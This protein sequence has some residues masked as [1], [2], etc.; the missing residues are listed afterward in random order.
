MQPSS[1]I[2]RYGFAVLAV[3]GAIVIRALLDPFLGD[4]QPFAFFFVA[5]AAAA[6]VG[7]VG[8]ALLAIV[9][10]YIAGDW[11]FVSPRHELSVLTLAPQYVVGGLA[12]VVVGLMIT[13][14]TSGMRAA[15]RFARERELDLAR[16]VAERATAEAAERDSQARLTGIIASATDA[17]ITIDAAHRITMFNA[18][19]ESM[20]GC[21][22]QTVIGETLDRFI[23]ERFR[24]GHADHIRGFGATGINMR[25]MGGERVLAGVRAGGQEF[26]MEA[27]ISQIAIGGEKLYTVIIRDITQRKRAEAE[28]DE[29]L[30]RER[31][32]RGEAEA[33]N[34]AKDSFL[35]T[36]SHEL[37]TPLSPILAWSRMLRQGHVDA[38]KMRGALDVIERCA[39]TQAQ[40]IEDM[41]DVSRI[42]SGK[43][44][45]QV[46]P[47]PLQRV[48]EN[49]VEVVRPAAEA[50]NVRLRVVL[51]TDVGPVLGDAERLQQVVW[52]LLSN[53][54]KFTP[55]DGRIQVAL[56]RVNSHVEVAVSDTGVGIRSETLPF[57]FEPFRQGETGTTR[58]HGGLGLGLAIVKHIVEA[59]GGTVHA[60]SPGEGKGAVFSVKLPL[61]VARTADEPERRHPTAAGEGDVGVEDGYPSLQGLRVLV[62]DDEPHSNEVVSTLL[63]SCG[64]EIRVAVSAPQAR[65]VL[66]RWT[67]DILVSDIEMPGEDGYEL[68]AKL[69]AQEGVGA[70]LPAVALTAYAS[71]EDN[72][73]LLS[74]GFHA[75]VAK[76][77][78]PLEL[79]TV[80][81]NL[82]R[83]AGRASA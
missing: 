82:A 58:T 9:L 83:T 30:V 16:E 24:A 18:A 70:Q 41:L 56:E 28:R 59:H 34:R 25:Q 50:K 72:I 45:M 5:I 54:I 74:A 46:R 12:F 27:R 69:R 61:A 51:D 31:A 38:E 55:K 75:H 68:I 81:A 35:A 14:I 10:G 48:I 73:R 42:I 13:G 32:A 19:A 29:L 37:R 44:R 77:L 79:V 36:I 20:F 67:P 40:L 47:V 65:E 21:S 22:A 66:G 62:V 4:Y 17:I 11:L 49:A 52:N 80:I 8:P 53:A 78:D 33:A 2:P 57:V 26:P 64:A 15:E 76:P 7:G 71:R 60:E 63:A 6:S 3:A 43:L 23:P 1:L 39:R